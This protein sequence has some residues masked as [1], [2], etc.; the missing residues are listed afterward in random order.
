MDYST[1][2]LTVYCVVRREA[3]DYLLDGLDGSFSLSPS[4]Y[5]IEMTENAI[6]SGRYEL[7]ESR[8]VWNNGLYTVCIYNQVGSTPMPAADTMI[9]DG[10]MVIQ[11]DTEI[12]NF[13]SS[14]PWTGTTTVL[15]LINQ[16]LPR[17]AGKP[18]SGLS[19]INGINAITNMIFKRLWQRK[20]DIVTAEI[21][22]VYAAGVP[23]MSVPSSF[24]GLK[25]HPQIPGKGELDKLLPAEK[26]GYYGITGTP[27][28]YE[29]RQGTLYVYPTPDI[30]TTIKMEYFRNPGTVDSTDDIVPFTGMF[31]QV[32]VEG[33]VN[34]ATLGMNYIQ[35]QAFAAFLDS[36]IEQTLPS[37]NFPI[38]SRR[39]AS[40]F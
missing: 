30:L 4:D 10:E 19:A 3:D 23:A 21:A 32:Y 17:V 31:N 8:Q 20:S 26:S 11:D 7:D 34:F 15:Q 6:T 38:R 13:L 40:Y 27:E 18:S 33:L 35:D 36:E 2:G 22:M 16:I 24:F 29:L 25:D 5:C 39:A 12:S 37:R 28:S 14:I 9:G 1:T